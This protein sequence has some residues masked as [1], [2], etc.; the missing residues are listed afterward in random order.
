MTTT[1]TRSSGSTLPAAGTHTS[2]QVFTTSSNFNTTSTTTSTSS[3]T[4]LANSVGSTSLISTST[5]SSTSSWSSSSSVLS[6]TSGI[7]SETAS[8]K[9][10]QASQ[11]NISGKGYSTGA[12]A[13]SIVGSFLGGLIIAFVIAFL[14]RRHRKRASTAFE[15]RQGSLSDTLEYPKDPADSLNK[16]PNS[17]VITGHEGIS[18]VSPNVTTLGSFD[19]TR[20]VPEPA[21]DATIC[22]RI[23]TFFDQAGLHIDNYY[24]RPDFAPR[25]NQEDIARVNDYGSAF[26]GKPLATVLSNSRNQRGVLTHVLIYNLLQ[27]IRPGNETRSLLPACYS[28]DRKH[29]E[30][31]SLDSDGDR[32]IFAWRMLTAYLSVRSRSPHPDDLA[33]SNEMIANI[34]NDFNRTFA[35]YSDSRFSQMERVSHFTTVVREASRLGSW[36]FSQPCSFEFHWSMASETSNLITVLPSVIKSHDEQGRRLVVPQTVLNETKLQI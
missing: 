34:A 8:P 7:T 30:H 22:M 20:F 9:L 15:K 1:P 25:Q 14:L 31:L 3:G 33:V 18:Q 17:S 16:I 26:L 27:S 23:Q 29:R 4:T 6:S 21:D 36:L 24:S 32:A 19:L 28:V 35:Q 11:K 2:N 10:D 13:G 5:E 12:L